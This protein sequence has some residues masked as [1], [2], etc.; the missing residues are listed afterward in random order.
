MRS[1]PFIAQ[2]ADALRP[3]Q[4]TRLSDANA[5]SL[6]FFSEGLEFRIDCFHDKQFA[7]VVVNQPGQSAAHPL[8]EYTFPF[9]YGEI[10]EYASVG[11]QA[12]FATSDGMVCMMLLI[13]GIER[14]SLQ[15]IYPESNQS[16]PRLSD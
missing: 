15:P 14:V 4:L 3:F 13:E 8:F 10:L 16:F 6:L 11:R 7:V 1:Q 2:L 9:Y 5:D 12:R